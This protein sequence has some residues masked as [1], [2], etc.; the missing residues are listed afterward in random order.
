M[1]REAE[2]AVLAARFDEGVRLVT[3]LGPG[4]I[5]KT[6]LAVEHAIRR[7]QSGA[8]TSVLFCDV[9]GV[10]D[11]AGIVDAMAIAC[12]A[13]AG[14][15]DDA[16]AHVGAALAA[17][18]EAVV[19]IDN[20]DGLAE[21]ALETIGRW[22]AHAHE[23]EVVVTSREQL[24]VASE[25]SIEVGPLHDAA[26][27]LV[28]AA[29]RNAV[30]FVLRPEDAAT[31]AEIV[32][33]LEGVP[34]AIEMAG[35][36]LPL[37]G[38]RALLDRVWAPAE[39]LRR[40]VRGGPS[41][42]A[43]LDA[44]VR[45]SFDAL[46]DH[47]RDVLAQLAVFRG[48][49]T[50]ESAEAVVELASKERAVVDVVAALR[51]R[52]LVRTRDAG[53]AR[54]DLYASVRSFVEREHPAP[55]AEAAERHATYFV[56]AAERAAAEAHRDAR[57]RAWLL[58]ERENVLAVAV[59]VLGAGAVT[60][61][62][63]EPALRGIV[64]LSP[65]LLARG[66][67]G[68]V[69]ALVAPVVERTRDSGADPRLSA[70]ATLL[71][72]AIRRERGDVRSALKD[73]L[74]AESIARALGD[75]LLGA[76]VRIELGRTLL[77]AGELRAARDH[78][79]KATAAFASLGARS[80]EAHA[81]A[82]L[83]VATAGGAID[84]ATARDLLER[85][86]ALEA[87]DAGSRAPY[88]FLLGRARAEL[89]DVAGA[90][91]ALE[92]SVTAAVAGADRRAE[93]CARM[94]LGL[95][96]HDAGD[97]ARAEALLASGRDAFAVLGLDLDAALARGYLGLVALEAGRPAEAY[98][99]LADARDVALHG[100]RPEER[101]FFDRHL[102]SLASA[103]ASAPAPASATAPAPASRDLLTS[104]PLGALHA[105]LSARVLQSQQATPPVA[106]P[107]DALVLGPEGAWFR[108]PASTRVGLER[109]RSLA[110]LLD[111]LA[112]ER[113][114]GSAATLSSAALFAAAWPGEKAIASA[115]A[116]RVRVAI[117][118]LRKMG[119]RDAILTHP[120]GYALAPSLRVVRA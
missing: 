93:A 30:G 108:A 50:V 11:A 111:R 4:G 107:D 105:R 17:R 52:S 77:V 31:A 69:A 20:F 13:A 82:W 62:S 81:L 92:E 12:G 25:V 55:I 19:V 118:T 79:E 28:A 21:H 85:A 96:A 74:T 23:L 18:G 32:T 45:G 102:A 15:G 94:L 33:L 35:A 34:L 66:P 57:A 43:S 87:A 8:R 98:A 91:S 120:D 88:S 39:G 78:F 59:R 109:R 89:G 73:L 9:E 61:R 51:A 117:A 1:G 103:S 115:A 63:A 116:H 99:L 80:R 72:G 71:R 24:G 36:R 10:R 46:E 41:R 84:V 48:G 5:G 47:E 65:L 42:H 60:A 76:D 83:A 110:L 16:V 58:V 38:A 104:W 29:S 3:L 2:L 53:A 106:F 100:G 54:F 6:A 14:G 64:A 7:V 113:H 75:A 114:A 22:L 97:L 86:V 49:F 70:R 26:R 101:A 112:T 37:L 90:A 40:D 56:A 68:S 44:A 27:L 95:V 119:L 67:L